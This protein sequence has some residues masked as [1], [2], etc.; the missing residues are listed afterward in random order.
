MNKGLA[1][2]TVPMSLTGAV[3]LWFLI[4]VSANAQQKDMLRRQAYWGAS[5]AAPAKGPGAKVRRVDRDSAAEKA[6]LKP[7][8][9]VLRI[10]GKPLVNEITYEAARRSVRGGDPVTLEVSR[11]SKTLLVKF[12]APPLPY[13]VIPGTEVRYESVVTERGH[14]L[15]TI[16]TKPA[17]AT[18]KLPAI[19]FVHWL[20]CDSV[21]SPLRLSDGWS[22][23]LRGL[24]EKSG[25]VLM[26]VERPGL[27]DSEGP[28][29][30][31]S[32]LDADMAGFRAGLRALKQYDFV[33]T[34]N[35]FIVGAS[36]GGALAPIL[37]QGENVRGMIVSGGFAKTWLEHMLEHER[38]RL[39]L[40]GRTPAEINE[41]MRGY[42]QFYSA[43]LNQRL[44]PGEVIRRM[45]QL[46]SIWYDEPGHQYGR[47]AAFFHQVQQLN[48]EGAWEKTSAP[49][50]IVYG[51]YDWIMSRDDQELIAQ[52]VNSR[53]PGNAKLVIAPKLDHDLA[54]Y[55]S[56]AKAFKDE[57]R[58]FD[59]SVITLMIDWLKGNLNKKTT[60]GLGVIKS[61][62]Q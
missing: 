41:W 20:S 14:R 19:L 49:V 31:Q 25:F 28:D 26:R 48:V 35:V 58:R 56:M 30:S 34:D 39:A 13:E 21:E 33:D 53:H 7:G 59:E 36:I 29:C 6:G 61:E 3:A 24:A 27:G 62:N 40:S 37:A 4:G 52:I 10:N 18:G 2:T 12:S 46:A 16:V 57:G 50:L 54:A 44:T 47:P 22:K 5:I 15:R 32:D 8:D 9:L 1:V 43:Y 38:R 23:I 45:P 17:N 42:S 55:D 51:E 11:E 60:A